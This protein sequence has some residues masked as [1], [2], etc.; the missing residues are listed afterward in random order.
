LLA[1]LARVAAGVSVAHFGRSGVGHRQRAKGR[2]NAK[3]KGTPA[4]HRAIGIV[5]A[6]GHVCTRAIGTIGLFDVVAAGPSDVKLI[7]LK[8]GRDTCRGIEREQLTAL[9]VPPNV[10]RECWR[11]SRPLPGAPDRTAIR[12]A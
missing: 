5:E 2:M 12:V 9:V 3:H 4:E 7:Q 1:V 10:K 11:P 6:A 8:A